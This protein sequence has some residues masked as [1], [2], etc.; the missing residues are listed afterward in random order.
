MNQKSQE[1]EVKL[2]EGWTPGKILSLTDNV[3]AFAMTLLILNFVIPSDLP[4]ENIQQLFVNLWPQFLTYFMSFA[5]L[6]TFWVGHHNLFTLIKHTDRKAVWI[7]IIFASFIVLIP[8]TTAVLRQYYTDQIAV[9]AY[10]FNMVVCGLAAYWLWQHTVK[11]KLLKEGVDTEMVSIMH[12]RIVVPVS[13]AVVITVVGFFA[14][15][16]SLFMFAI[17]FFLVT[18]PT[19]SDSVAGFIRGFLKK[20]TP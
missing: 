9:V 3:F 17:L 7:N 8:L 19:V 16:V 15:M 20:G 18:I 5:V 1:L 10:G 14:P 11:H 12:F 13:G 2:A 6:G 4:S